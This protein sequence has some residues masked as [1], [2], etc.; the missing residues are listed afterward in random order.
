MELMAGEVQ[1]MNERQEK[2]R[3]KLLYEKK[4]C[5]L[6]FQEKY[7]FPCI[8][9]AHRVIWLLQQKMLSLASHARLLPQKRNAFRLAEAER[10][11]AK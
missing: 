10:G 3:N 9:H 7:V 8:S 5:Y 4:K 2:E 6:E 1:R 11:R